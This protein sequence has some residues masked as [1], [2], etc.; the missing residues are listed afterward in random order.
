MRILHCSPPP[1]PITINS[2]SPFKTI[3]LLE[4]ASYTVKY[5]RAMAVAIWDRKKATLDQGKKK[6]PPV[7]LYDLTNIS[8][9]SN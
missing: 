8:S 6:N 5:Y 2:Y 1:L 9:F 3:L 4:S 7:F